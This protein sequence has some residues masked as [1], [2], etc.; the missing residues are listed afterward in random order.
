MAWTRAHPPLMAPKF[1]HAKS[2][3]R[4][5][6]QYRLGP[7]EW[8]RLGRQIRRRDEFGGQVGLILP[9]VAAKDAAKSQRHGS[10]GR[11][12]A[13]HNVSAA[14]DKAIGRD[15]RRQFELCLL[16]DAMATIGVDIHHGENCRRLWKLER[17]IE[18]VPNLHIEYPRPRA[19]APNRNCETA[20]FRHL[21]RGLDA[22]ARTAAHT[23]SL[24]RVAARTEPASAGCAIWS[25]W[26][27]T[28][29]WT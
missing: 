20:Q 2:E 8:Q 14:I 26:R 21:F 10:S 12:Q 4:S 17:N 6:S 3:R 1:A 27:S 18:T 23:P 25:A 19:G 13:S 9:P 28:R 15:R 7:K 22:S 16:G 29:S 11:R 5:V 24:A